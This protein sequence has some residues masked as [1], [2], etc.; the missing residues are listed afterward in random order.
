MVSWHPLA[1]SAQIHASLLL[2]FTH[3]MWRAPRPTVFMNE[4]TGHVTPT[5]HKPRAPSVSCPWPAKSPQ[6]EYTVHSRMSAEAPE[7]GHSLPHSGSALG[8]SPGQVSLEPQNERCT[9]G[10]GSGFMGQDSGLEPAFSKVTRED[11]D[12]TLSRRAH[13]ACNLL[14]P[15]LTF[16]S[17]ATRIHPDPAFQQLQSIQHRGKALPMRSLDTPSTHL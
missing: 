10:P 16:P 8:G 12:G 5:W 11:L 13:T 1:F 9:K 17:P 4:E 7:A 14:T 15:A 3:G 6:G 2:T